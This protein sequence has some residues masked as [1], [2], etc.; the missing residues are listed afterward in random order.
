[1]EGQRRPRVLLSVLALLA[2]IITPG[3]AQFSSLMAGPA[4]APSSFTNSGRPAHLR[5]MGTA[6]IVYPTCTFGGLVYNG[7]RCPTTF[8]IVIVAQYQKLLSFARQ[9]L[10]QQATSDFQALVSAGWV[11]QTAVQQAALLETLSM[12]SRS[13]LYAQIVALINAP[14]SLGEALAIMYYSLESEQLAYL[15]ASPS[16]D[17]NLY[18]VLDQYIAEP[19]Q[20]VVLLNDI[21]PYAQVVMLNNMLNCYEQPSARPTYPGYTNPSSFLAPS[22]APMAAAGPALGDNTT[23]CPFPTLTSYLTPGSYPCPTEIDDVIY[24]LLATEQTW[25]SQQQTQFSSILQSYGPPLAAVGASGNS[26]GQALGAYQQLSASQKALALNAYALAGGAAV[27]L[28]QIIVDVWQTCSPEQMQWILYGI[29][30]F[31]SGLEQSFVNDGQN[32]AA[33][34]NDIAALSPWFQAALYDL[35]TT[36]AAPPTAP[37]L[38]LYSAIAPAFTAPPLPPPPP[39]SSVIFQSP[40]PSPPPPPPP[41]PL[42]AGGPTPSAVAQ[43]PPP[44]PPFPPPPGPQQSSPGGGTTPL[45]SPGASNFGKAVLY[46][47]LYLT[48]QQRQCLYQI[49]SAR[50]DLLMLFQLSA[51]PSFV[52]SMQALSY[53]DQGNV[54]AML[55]SATVSPCLGATQFPGSQQ[56]YGYGVPPPPPPPPQGF[57]VYNPPPPPPPPPLSPLD[58]PILASQMLGPQFGGPGST[59][60]QRRAAMS[61]RYLALTITLKGDAGDLLPFPISANG[62]DKGKLVC[63]A[64]LIL[65]DPVF[66]AGKLTCTYING[67]AI[68]TVAQRTRMLL[69]TQAAASYNSTYGSISPQFALPLPIAS[70]ILQ[71]GMQVYGYTAANPASFQNALEQAAAF[72]NYTLGFT[73]QVTGIAPYSGTVTTSTCSKPWHSYCLDGTSLTAG[74]VDG[75]IVGCV[76]FVVI[77]AVVLGVVVW[78]RRRLA[79]HTAV[80]QHE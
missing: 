68:F 31:V 79:G 29:D 30:E 58:Q 35:V 34:T 2:A 48:P 56:V 54:A 61:A 42:V 9:N 12:G 46:D 19:A 59:P 62:F 60:A 18:A 39:S 44:P 43:S 55:T 20:A 25:T 69:Q 40:P 78:R 72:Y 27:S 16:Y 77:V 73:G 21:T 49:C 15:A 70:T 71:F 8:G 36:P 38:Q 22:L 7:R 14:P 5:P 3:A 66:G 11:Q 63:K 80:P 4:M 26:P 17:P 23:L 64:L 1:M 13:N 65:L 6:P 45:V 52:Q 47:Y 75:I 24:L 41:P 53:S 33:L 32:P 10:F 37:P 28:P 74:G 50:P 67:T 76:F 51:A 57:G